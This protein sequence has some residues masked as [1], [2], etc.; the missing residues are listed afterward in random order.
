MDPIIDARLINPL[1]D[2]HYKTK[3]D[4]FIHISKEGQISI[5]VK[6]IVFEITP[7]GDKL[8]VNNKEISMKEMQ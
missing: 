3:N 4:G 5:K 7:D 6:N 2:F 8:I 1:E